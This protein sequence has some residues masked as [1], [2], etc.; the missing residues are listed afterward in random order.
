LIR[1]EGGRLLREKRYKEPRKASCVSG[2]QQPSV[3]EPKEKGGA[4]MADLEQ[5]W[6]WKQM[7]SFFYMSNVEMENV[8]WECRI[9]DLIQE[10]KMKELMAVYGLGIKA[11]GQN[12]TGMYLAG[13]F[14]YLCGGMHFLSCSE[15]SVSSENIKLQV[16]ERE[17]G[18]MLISFVTK[19]VGM[20]QVSGGEWV[21][22]IYQNQLTPIYQ[23]IS[24][25]SDNNLL[26][27]WYQA[28]HSLYWIKHRMQCSDLFPNTLSNYEK[29]M[30][31][32]IQ[33]TNPGLFGVQSSTHPYAKKLIFIDNPW[34]LDAPM[35][36]KPS[37]CLAYNTDGGHYCYTCPKMKR[38]VREE[39]FKKV[40]LQHSATS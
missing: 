3:T 30:D 32:F 11:K 22:L 35:P 19:D 10:V 39:K 38:E 2:N 14:G 26:H 18:G 9:S 16:Y 13:W 7:E 23:L 33:N 15:F 21:N 24:T 29:V 20:K 28:A 12:V 31:S 6:T 25:I 17:N 40:L 34:D 4:E 37:C 27:M 1:A 8:V 5:T 36:L